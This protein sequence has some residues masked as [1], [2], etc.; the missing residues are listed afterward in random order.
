MMGNELPILQVFQL[1]GSSLRSLT[2]PTFCNDFDKDVWW[3]KERRD[4]STKCATKTIHLIRLY[5]LTMTSIFSHSG[6]DP[7]SKQ[8]P[9]DR[10]PW[11]ADQVR[12]NKAASLFRILKKRKLH[13]RLQSFGAIISFLILPLLLTS[14]SIY[15]PE[16]RNLKPDQLT[17]SYSLFRE[18]SSKTTDK[19]WESFNSEELNLLIEK[20]LKNNLDIHQAR[21]RMR[22]AKAALEKAGGSTAPSFA[23]TLQSTRSRMPDVEDTDTY[24]FDLSASYELDMW[25]RVDAL[26]KAENFDFQ[27]SKAD[28]ETSAMTVAASIAETWL[29][30]ISIR[31]E[32]A[33]IRSQLQSNSAL[34]ELLN[35]RFE[36]AMADV[37]D[38]LQQQEV[39]ASSKSQIPLLE[40]R[41]KVLINN[42]ALLLGQPSNEGITLQ[43]NQ[44]PDMPGFPVLGIPADLLE[45]RPD[46]RSAGLNIKSSDWDIAAARAN[47]LPAMTLTGSHVYS[48][49][50]F[51]TLFD[52]WVFSLGASLVANLYDGGTKSAEVLRLEAGVEEELASYK[53]T[54]FEAIIEVENSI[55]NEK[56]QIEYLNV[57]EQQLLIARQ[58]LTEA[59]RQY[60]KGLQSFIPVITEIPKVQSL[61]KQVVT[62]KVDLLKYR[63]ALYR[64]LGGSWT[65]EWLAVENSY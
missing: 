20:G 25:G 5:S 9:S 50:E 10:W 56:K 3:I 46:I 12:D 1:V 6:L 34:L 65:G 36:N 31:Q 40:A 8:V 2:H 64:S 29:D 39:L 24:S 57:L 16:E 27:A 48:S 49:N 60:T 7:E 23:G 37:L 59:E 19:W 28:L 55:I 62:E 18:S 21:A 63:I 51:S 61:E 14:C 38:V 43:Q 13:G 35:L 15:E 11:I 45:N 32:I 33:I 54:V 53:Q 41:E 44:L 30:V 58:A 42:L 52:N 17:E 47:R 4:G 22:Q 26:I